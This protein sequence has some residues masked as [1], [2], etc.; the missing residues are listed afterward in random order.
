MLEPHSFSFASDSLDPEQ[1]F[2]RFKSFFFFFF[3]HKESHAHFFKSSVYYEK[4]LRPFVRIGKITF[5]S[6]AQIML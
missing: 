1:R 2:R 5:L 6:S 3:F 4:C